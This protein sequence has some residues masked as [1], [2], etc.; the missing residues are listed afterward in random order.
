MIGHLISHRS[1]LRPL[2]ALA[3]VVAALALAGCNTDGGMS[4]N[5]KASKPIPAK[6]LAL[7]EEKHMTKAS[8]MLVRIFKQEAELEV[9]KK[10]DS[11][12][13]AKLK[14]FPICRWSGDLGPK[15]KQGDRQ[16]PE[17]FYTITPGQMNPNSSYYL[18]F[19]IGFPNAY[20]RANDRDGKFLMIHGDCSSA[21]CYAMTDE[22]ISEIYALARE[23]FAGGQRAFQI[24]AYPFHMTA[25]NLARH[26]NNPNMAFWKM[27]KQGN[28]IFEVSGQEPKV[29]VC[30]KHYVFDAEGP[31]GQ[32]APRFNPRGQ[33]PVYQM[34]QEIAAAVAQ[35]ERQDDAQVAS[36]V[37][38]GLKTAPIRMATDG[39]MNRVF[40]A[41]LG[42]PPMDGDDSSPA[43]FA[44]KAPG[45]IPPYVSPPQPGVKGTL[46]ANAEPMGT[47]TSPPAK[48]A[49]ALPPIRPTA[50]AFVKPPATKPAHTQIAAARPAGTTTANAAHHAA[51]TQV[52]AAGAG[53]PAWN[54]TLSSAKLSS[55]AAAKPAKPVAVHAKKPAK[56][57]QAAK[58]HGTA[59]ASATSGGF[60]NG[61]APALSTTGFGR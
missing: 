27:L 5:A 33:C 11:G 54:A 49:I 14:S 26:R 57:A 29:D 22:Q 17:G 10:D 20:D 61:A 25:K 38:S 37:S 13:Y 6:T 12:R 55:K 19:N 36:L 7:M 59:F 30:D 35:K 24:Q 43:L 48:T 46:L 2:A 21:G 8:P 3:A 15:V 45:T 32:P 23:S 9:W 58:P 18:A 4:P 60:V 41:A 56:D 44:E 39:G 50:V 47:P 53:A 28:D 31:A 51:T 16:A 1:F 52:A 34:P 40:L 42:R